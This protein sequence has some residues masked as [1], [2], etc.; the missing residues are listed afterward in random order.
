MKIEIML[1]GGVESGVT[2]GRSTALPET[3]ETE[4]ANNVSQAAAMGFGI[5]RKQLL[6]KTGHIVRKMQIQTPF[7]EGF[8]CC[9]FHIRH[10]GTTCLKTQQE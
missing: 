2:I 1:K 7:K 6:I 4:I 8:P 10:S 9:G 3:I 5:S